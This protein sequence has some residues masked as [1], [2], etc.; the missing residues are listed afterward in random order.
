MSE[1]NEYTQKAEGAKGHVQAVNI[2][3][4][5]QHF[6][7]DRHLRFV[8]IALFCL[9]PVLLILIKPDVTVTYNGIPPEKFSRLSEELGVTK[10]VL[11]S[12]FKILEQKQ[13]SPEDLDTLREIAK[14]YKE[15]Q[16]KL[17]A[18][19]IQEF[20]KVTELKE[21]AKK[22]LEKGDF[23]QAEEY[24]K[25]SVEKELVC[26][27][28][29][30]EKA[31]KCKLSAAKTNAE[32]GDLANTQ[33]E[34]KK[35]AEYYKKA[36]ELAQGIP[37]SELTLTGYLKK[38]GDACR[39]AGL[40]AEA[41]KTLERSLEIREKHLGKEHPSVAAILNNLSWLYYSQGKYE[42]AEPLY[43][44]A[45]AI[46]EKVLRPE[47]P[48]VATTLSNLAEMYRAQSKY[49]EAE[50]LY[51]RA[52][53]ISEKVLGLEHPNVAVTL[54]NLAALYYSQDRYEEAKPLYK[55][56]LATREKILGP[57]HPDVAVTLDNLA[58]LYRAQGKYEEAEPLFKRALAISEKVLG[59][60]HP[61]VAVTLNNLAGLYYSQSKYEE[62]E[63]LYKRAL[64][65]CEKALGP[66]HPNTVTARNNLNRLLRTSKP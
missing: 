66:N 28:R 14:R 37:D 46:S 21:K 20:P 50:P 3:K 43:K 57:E 4:L 64:A 18:R 26:A 59:L 12:F 1:K 63:P 30:E 10:F 22:A 9:I 40:Y 35:A 33:L 27:M 38:Q 31:R 19:S 42:E 65:I 62:A 16:A 36:A 7:Q 17:S 15:L 56:A 41:E 51:R 6:Y 58:E 54:N 2:G 24:L 52:L 49:E 23:D 47:H 45:L 39:D 44:R 48:D 11:V 53:A 29:F 5:V 60:E 61:N 55:R 34:Y 13:V 8:V 25:K 32:L